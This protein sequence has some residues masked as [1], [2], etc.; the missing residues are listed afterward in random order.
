MRPSR[1][2]DLLAWEELCHDR[3]DIEHW[4]S[5]DCIEFGNEQL[6]AFDSDNTADSATDSIRTVLAALREDAD[7]WP[8]SVV[9]RM[10][11]T[12]SDLGWF[13]LMEEEENFDMGELGQ[14]LQRLS[15]EPL[16]KGYASL[17]SAPEVIF[18]VGANCLNKPDCFNLCVHRDC[19][20]RDA[21][22]LN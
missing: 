18:R 6:G 8:G 11:S 3:L 20:F 19:S 9:P 15:R 21:Q 12:S 22:R 13:D 14:P 7:G 16:G 17:L 10:P 5:V 4:R 2:A 1:L